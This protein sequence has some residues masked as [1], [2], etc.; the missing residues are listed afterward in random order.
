MT[1]SRR[2]SVWLVLPGG[3][4]QVGSYDT[5]EDAEAARD[6]MIEAGA[7]GVTIVDAGEPDGDAL[8]GQAGLVWGVGR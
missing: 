6:R 7:V 8:A 1:M 4:V 3:E 5:V 2:F